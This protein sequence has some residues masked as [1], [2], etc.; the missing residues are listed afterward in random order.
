MAVTVASDLSVNVSEDQNVKKL[1]DKKELLN[2]SIRKGEPKTMGICQVM[3]GFLV[4]SYSIPLLHAQLTEVVKFGVPWWSSLTFVTAGAMALVMER[5][6]SIQLVLACLMITVVA[7]FISVLAVIFY[8]V[9]L[10]KNPEDPCMSNHAYSEQMCKHLYHS[11][12]FSREIKS[13]LLCLNVVQTGISCAF[14]FMLYSERR[15]FIN[16]SLVN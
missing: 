14:S 12:L 3:V 8:V 5:R 11:S 1:T 4:I 13:I 15:R 2:E 6:N 10:L 7:A 16:Y 9:D